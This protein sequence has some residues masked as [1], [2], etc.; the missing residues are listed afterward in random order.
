[1]TAVGDPE[2]SVMI[3]GRIVVAPGDVTPFL[4]QQLPRVIA[5]R[6]EPGCLGYVVG[7]DPV[8]EGVVNLFEHW[9]NKGA[10]AAHLE[11]LASRTAPASPGVAVVKAL[12][13]Q[14][15][16]GPPSRVGA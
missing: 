8:E 14:Y 2:G 7:A 5:S 1:M 13:R 15:E 11:I 4:A 3:V 16:A 10:L 9:E 6:A 12:I